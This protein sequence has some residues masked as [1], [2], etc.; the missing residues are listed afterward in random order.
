[1]RAGTSETVVRGEFFALGPPAW[2]AS[3]ALACECSDRASG[4]R[5]TRFAGGRKAIHSSRFGGI[6]IGPLLP[7]LSR[8]EKMVGGAHPTAVAVSVCPLRRDDG[9]A[10]GTCS[11]GSVEAFGDGDRLRRGGRAGRGTGRGTVPI[12]AMGASHNASP[13][14]WGRCGLACGRGLRISSPVACSGWA[15]V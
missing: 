13:S 12:Y 4:V 6:R 11:R 8:S 3:G 1:M 9:T 10:P 5:S 7:R 2:N 15:M 14:S